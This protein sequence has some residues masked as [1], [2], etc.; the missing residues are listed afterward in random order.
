M[1]DP[2]KILLY[3]LDATLQQ[4]FN[5]LK[6]IQGSYTSLK[7]RLSNINVDLFDTDTKAIIQ[8]LLDGNADSS[9]LTI[10]RITELETQ[11]GALSGSVTAGGEEGTFSEKFTY[12]PTYGNVTK[13]EVTGDKAYT[14]DYTYKDLANG[15]LDYSEKKYID[16]D[17]KNVTIKKVY[18]YDPNGN[19]TDINTTTTKV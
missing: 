6:D 10:E 18:I 12:D 1:S 7:E 16:A 13:H 14:V 3:D 19:I 9:K 11:L 17:S 5:D 8:D 4:V 2:T 15:T